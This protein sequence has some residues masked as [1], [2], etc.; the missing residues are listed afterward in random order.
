MVAAMVVI[1]A[2]GLFV[3]FQ[4][5]RDRA[6]FQPVMIPWYAAMLFAVVP[7]R[8]G[9]PDSPPIGFLDRHHCRA[10]GH[11]CYGCEKTRTSRPS[12]VRVWQ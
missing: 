1:A 3:A 11:R 5:V 10:V 6:K 8:N 2:L 4:T 9:L 7:L 12:R